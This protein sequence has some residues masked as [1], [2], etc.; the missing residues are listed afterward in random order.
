[1]A[2]GPLG[3]I[4]GELAATVSKPNN[5]SSEAR[6]PSAKKVEPLPTADKAKISA[7]IVAMG[8][9]ITVN[10]ETY[11]ASEFTSKI[12]KFVDDLEVR[13]DGDIAHVR[14]ASRTGY[15]DRGV[16]RKR[17]EDLRA[18]LTAG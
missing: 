3:L 6:T 9:E 18:R 7:A 13:L 14:S 10:D 5:V 2:K 12:F 8:G 1:M 17:V 15:S 11:L 16:N 4:N